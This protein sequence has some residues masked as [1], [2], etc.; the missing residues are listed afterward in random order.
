MGVKEKIISGL[1][2]L[3]ILTVSHGAVAWKAY[4]M[5]AT[6]NEAAHA[7]KNTAAVDKKIE[8]KGK[9]DEISNNRPTVDRVIGRL[10]SGTF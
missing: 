5:G 10:F 3:L 9:Q 1:V 4:N 7:S 2:L 6:V 8:I